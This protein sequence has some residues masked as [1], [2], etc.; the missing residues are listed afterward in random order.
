MAE[1]RRDGA[2]GEF[3]LREGDAAPHGTRRDRRLRGRPRPPPSYMMRD[4]PI[5]RRLKERG[6]LAALHP[7]PPVHISTISRGRISLA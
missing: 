4:R 3:G 1:R 2:G 5:A 6:E 7:R